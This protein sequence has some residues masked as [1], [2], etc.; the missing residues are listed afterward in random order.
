M[1]TLKELSEI[2]GVSVSTI[3]KALNDS[4]DISETTKKR[5]IDLAIEHGYIKTKKRSSS[6]HEGEPVIAVIYSDIT[7]NYYS[8]LME[9]FDTYISGINGILLMSCAEFETKRIIKLCRFFESLGKVDG[10]I[11]VSP[12]NVFGDIPKSS[13]PMVGISYPSFET[14]PFD[15]ICIDDEVGIDEGVAC[16]KEYGHE[17]IAFL[18]ENFTPHRLQFFKDSM[19]RHG[20]PLD[21]S[22]IRVSE[23]RFEQ[24]GYEMMH[25]ILSEGNIPTAVF[26]A[27]DDIAVGAANAIL[28]A[29]LSIPED[30]SIAGID[31]TMC[32]LNGQNMLSSVNCHMEEQ[33]DIAVNLLIKKL[34]EPEFKVFQNVNMRTSFIKRDSISTAKKAVYK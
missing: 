8:R 16:F 5:I 23:K 28:E 7:S 12:F 6:D 21:Q 34:N 29:G 31:N 22:L 10:I 27:Y 3:S 4:S 33:V 20:I 9:L 25:N 18:S 2:A 19:I 17:K 14:H 26:A 24:A 13:L 11:C 30:I 1:P 32:I 15:Y